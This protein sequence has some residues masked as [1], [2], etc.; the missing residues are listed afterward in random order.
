MTEELDI[1]NKE[2]MF[3]LTNLNAWCDNPLF[4]KAQT[5]AIYLYGEQGME[6]SKLERAV[7]AGTIIATKEFEKERLQIIGNCSD[8]EEGLRRKIADLEKQIEKM[9]CCFNCKHSRTEYEHC[10]TNKH[11]KWEIK[12]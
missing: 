7:M 8:R 2:Q 6:V 4:D 1:K 12:E 11:E 5:I 3:E 10:K 9:K